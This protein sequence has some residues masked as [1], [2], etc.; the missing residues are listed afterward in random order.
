MASVFFG[1]LVNNWCVFSNPG[2]RK[3]G[4]N[5]G[6]QKSPL[7]MLIGG[8]FYTLGKEE[9]ENLAPEIHEVPTAKHCTH[10]SMNDFKIWEGFGQ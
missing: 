5:V 7:N 4:I 9:Q 10:A 3:S 8:N 2:I 1:T 6:Y